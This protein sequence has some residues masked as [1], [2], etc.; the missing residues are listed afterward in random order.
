[1]DFYR[2]LW[3]HTVETWYRRR[4]SVSVL[5]H[6][7]AMR[8]KNV[9]QNNVNISYEISRGAKR[10]SNLFCCVSPIPVTNKISSKS[11]V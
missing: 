7:A 10:V 11:Y 9:T 4:L 1:M 5:S 3:V 8:T 6:R 2:P